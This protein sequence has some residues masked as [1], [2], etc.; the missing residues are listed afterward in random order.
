MV[1]TFIALSKYALVWY[2][3]SNQLFNLHFSPMTILH[4]V[5]RKKGTQL[6]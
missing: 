4:G 2:T 5:L 3:I 6:A 1:I